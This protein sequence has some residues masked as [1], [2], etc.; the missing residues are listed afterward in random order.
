MLELVNLGLIISIGRIMPDIYYDENEGEELFLENR[1]QAQG[2]REEW[3]RVPFE[4]LHIN[5]PHRWELRN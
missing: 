3:N 4:E 1:L 2:L 5:Q